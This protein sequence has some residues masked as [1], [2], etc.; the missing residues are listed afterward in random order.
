MP[1]SSGNWHQQDEFVHLG[2]HWSTSKTPSPYCHAQFARN[3]SHEG[4][5]SV[6][7]KQLRCNCI[8]VKILAIS[9]KRS[10][11]LPTGPDI[12][13]CCLPTCLRPLTG[14][15]TEGA[16]QLMHLDDP[17]DSVLA[18]ECLCAAS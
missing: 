2:R 15:H 5:A 16:F 4:D 13:A 10:H 17:L 8:F 11:L 1:L 6:Q 3:G 18:I 7:G 9:S 14:D 12:T